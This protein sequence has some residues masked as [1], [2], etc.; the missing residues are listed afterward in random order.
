[1]RYDRS[2]AAT[3]FESARP[4]RRTAGAFLAG[5][6]ILLGVAWLLAGPAAVN[7]FAAMTHQH[8]TSVHMASASG[9]A[10]ERPGA[11]VTP[12]SCEK[13]AHVPG[14]T[15]T[16][17]RVDY[18]PNGASPPHRHGGSVFA[19][20]LSGTVRSQITGE[21]LGTFKAGG[22]WFEPLGVTHLVSENASTTEPASILAV[23][24][25]D[26]C[27]TLTTYLE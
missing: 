24:V 16:T 3:A 22:T 10:A 8:G 9:A 19:Y 11:T 14:K 27:A 15:M 1:M 21:P 17:V 26:D 25:A 6:A 12:I 5:S 2:A 13:L 18:P 20:V 23:F 7:P 4:G